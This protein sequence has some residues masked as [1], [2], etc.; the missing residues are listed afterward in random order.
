MQQLIQVQLGPW[1]E[2]VEMF[3]WDQSTGTNAYE[4]IGHGFNQSMQR[5]GFQGSWAQLWKDHEDI[6]WVQMVAPEGRLN[7]YRAVLQAFM[8]AA[9]IGHAAYKQRQAQIQS[10]KA[11]FHLPVGMT[12]VSTRCVQLLHYPP[13][14]A[15]TYSDYLYS[16]TNRRC[17]ALLRLNGVKADKL[18]AMERVCDLVP[19]AAS[20]SNA[21]VINDVRWAFQDYAQAM[22]LALLPVDDKRTAPVVAYGSSAPEWFMRV[23]ED[24]MKKQFKKSPKVLDVAMIKLKKNDPTE[25]PVLFANHPADYLMH[26]AD[27]KKP[28]APG[29][30][31]PPSQDRV[32]PTQAVVAAQPASSPSTQVSSGPPVINPVKRP[33]SKATIMKEDLIAARWQ[34]QMAAD[35]HADPKKTLQAAKAHWEERKSEIARAVKDHDQEFNFAPWKPDA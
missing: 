35:W 16:N 26:D 7:G 2:V 19:L 15:R 34:A 24:Q 27:S 33:V 13:Y 9:R 29:T 12:F 32:A 20:G 17:E 4:Y 3:G 23:Y 5:D 1:S 22:L 18:V 14:E 11:I 25:T 28:S 8:A 21:P 6:L 10:Q 31:T 30:S